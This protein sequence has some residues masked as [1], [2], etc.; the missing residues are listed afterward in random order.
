M[1]PIILAAA[2]LIANASALHAG[3]I[4]H[5]G[6]GT[7]SAPATG[8]A[9]VAAPNSGPMIRSTRPAGNAEAGSRSV[10]PAPDTEAPPC[11]ERQSLECDRA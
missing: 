2:A 3:S 6:R 1:R 10:A 4:L 11:D 8:S 7:A 9:L 5:V